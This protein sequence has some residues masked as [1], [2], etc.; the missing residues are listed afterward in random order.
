MEDER[1]EADYSEDNKITVHNDFVTAL[2][3]KG[4]TATDL[5]MMRFIISQCRMSDVEFYEYS[6]S[7]TD[8]AGRFHIDRDHMYKAAHESIARLFS[9]NLK[10]G[11]EKK[12]EL[13][14]IFRTAKYENGIF[15][16]RLSEES[17]KLF[18]QLRKNFTNVPLLPVLSMKSKS[19]IRIFELL[20]EKLKGNLPFADNA[21][22]LYVDLGELRQVT[23]TLNAKSYDRMT[24]FK[25]RVVNPSIAEIEQAAGWKIVL[26]NVKKGKSITGFNFEIW[27]RNGWEYI[28]DCKA[29]GIL[30]YRGKYGNDENQVPGQMTFADYFK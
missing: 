24:N 25:K 17:N 11:T 29:K 20:C 30:P 4:I 21:M 13:F 12:Y 2:Y 6:F 19:S 18:L 8:I 10:V 9:C 27:S 22:S 14:H 3:P 16:M 23:E 15:T 26:Q 7:V 1:R 5:K 28:E